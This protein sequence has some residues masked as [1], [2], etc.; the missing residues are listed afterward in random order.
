MIKRRFTIVLPALPSDGRTK[1]LAKGSTE[2]TRLQLEMANM[3]VDRIKRLVP[4]PS[5]RN[6]R[7]PPNSP[8]SFLDFYY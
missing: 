3:R 2:F 1:K 5:D 6:G 7:N 8:D 4:A